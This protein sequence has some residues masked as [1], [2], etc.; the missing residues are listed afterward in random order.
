[1]SVSHL[2]PRHTMARSRQRN[3]VE[4]YFRAYWRTYV[5]VIGWVVTVQIILSAILTPGTS[6]S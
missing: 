2:S 3:L 4:L 1:M 5:L 6:G